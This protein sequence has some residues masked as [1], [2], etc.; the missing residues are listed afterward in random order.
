MLRN[1]KPNPRAERYKKF[2]KHVMQQAIDAVN[3]GLTLKEVGGDLI[4]IFHYTVYLEK[5]LNLMF[6]FTFQSSVAESAKHLFCRMMESKRTRRYPP[7]LRQFA[8][9][10]ERLR[11]V[12]SNALPH[13]RTLSKW[14][15]TTDASPDFMK[16]SIS[17]LKL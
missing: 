2:D 9:T 6:F 10:Q 4:F 11:R 1:C 12:F 17:A 3:R 8:L 7:E 16:D 15:S 14:Y 13:D 5:K